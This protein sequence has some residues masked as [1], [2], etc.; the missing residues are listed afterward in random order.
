MAAIA[1]SPP[2]YTAFGGLYTGLIRL[3]LGNYP[4]ET[5]MTVSNGLMTGAWFWGGGGFIALP[6]PLTFPDG[7]YLAQYLAGEIKENLC[8]YPRCA[9]FEWA[10]AGS[11]NL[12]TLYNAQVPVGAT[13][14][15]LIDT[16]VAA[17]VSP[18]L[19]QVASLTAQ[20]TTMNTQLI[21]CQA[22]LNDATA[23]IA[24]LTQQLA[25]CQG[26]LRVEERAIARKINQAFLRS[27]TQEP[28]DC[29]PVDATQACIED[30]KIPKLC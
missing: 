29:E 14:Q 26:G 28:C 30:A 22:A 19:T 25:D 6:L 18:L 7:G 11:T 9:E 23:E 20:L 5:I 1:S 3:W 27:M 10:I 16:A 8:L 15:E 12:P 2:L 21:T 4:G 24:D 17:A 13:C